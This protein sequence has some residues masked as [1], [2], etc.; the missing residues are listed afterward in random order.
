MMDVSGSMG[1]EQKEIVRIESFWIDTW[2]TKQY[3]RA[4]VA[5]HHPRRHGARG[6]P[7]HLLPHPRVGGTMISSAYKLCNQ[8]IEEHYPP[9]S[10][11]STRSTSPTATTG[12]WTTRVA[13]SSS[14]KK[15]ILP[16]ANMFAYGQ[17]ESPTAAASSSRTCA[18]AFKA[19]ERVVTQRDP[20]DKDDRTAPSRTSSGRAGNEQ[21]RAQHGA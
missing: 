17:V 14:S 18:S 10:G 4:R 9:T 12:R 1:D 5:L 2:L 11:T 19:D 3:K 20:S 7:R 6:R 15:E 21:V 13:A 16:R 8:M